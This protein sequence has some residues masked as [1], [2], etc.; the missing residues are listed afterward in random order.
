MNVS[1]YS[2]EAIEAVIAQGD[3]PEKTAVISFIMYAFK[4]SVIDIIYRAAKIIDLL[5]IC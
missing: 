4:I 5:P 3:F 1:I 2:R